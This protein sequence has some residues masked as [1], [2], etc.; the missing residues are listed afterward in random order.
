MAKTFPNKKS[1]AKDT[2]SQ[3][4][5]YCIHFIFPGSGK[6]QVNPEYLNEFKNKVK[7]ENTS[8]IS[9]G[10]LFKD[11]DHSIP[12]EILQKGGYAV[13]LA[14]GAL[15]KVFNPNEFLRLPLP[16][17][18]QDKKYFELSFK[19]KNRIDQAGLI[20]PVEVLKYLAHILNYKSLESR[21]LKPIL[22]KLGFTRQ[23][24]IIHQE[25]PVIPD[26][27]K[28]SL[29]WERVKIDLAWNTSIPF[30]ETR[31]ASFRK[32][33]QFS[34]NP[35][36][37][38]AF[39]A[40]ALAIFI[41][42]PILSLDAGLSGDDTKHYN[43]AVKVFRYF[44]EDDPSALNDPKYKLN[45]YG[46]SF[47]FFTYLIIRLFNLEENPYEARHVMVALTGAATI[48]CT[49]LLV[50][51][52]AGYS[53]GWIALILMF[54][55]PR[56]LGHAF[57]NPM[58]VPFALGNIFT[59][60]HIILFLKKLP[61][62]STRSALWIALGIGWSNGIRI[63]GLLLVPYLFLFAGLYLLIH[64]W[65]W[66]FFSSGWWRFALRGLL[67]LVLISVA[68]YLLS[69]LTWPY[70]LQDIINH[71]IQAFKVMTNIQV[72]IR[73]LYD[74][75]IHWSD[76][77]PWHYIPQN[78]WISVPVII[79]VGWMVSAL[80]WYM[81]R[82]LKQGYFYFM[83]WFTILFPV[84]FIIYRES[85]VYGGWRHMMFIYPSMLA[86]AAMSLSRFL[87]PGH[88]KWITY[89]A[90]AVLAVG[91]FHP[92]RHLIRNHPNTY[93]YFNE[94]SGGIKNT[95]GSFETDYYANSLKPA[96]DIFIEEILPEIDASEEHRVRVVSNSAIG[97]YF[98]NHRD[99]VETLYSR[100]YDRGKYDW[101]YAILYCNYLHP[102]QLNNGLWP[103]K[104]TIKEIRVDDVVV[105]AIIERKNKD[106][107][108]GSTL[109]QKG[110]K[111]Q[112][113]NK[114][115]DA[116]ELLE[117]AI[118]YD[119]H[120][121]IAFL[122][123][124]NGYSA[125]LRF[126]ESRAAM[127]RLLEYYPDYDKALNTKGYSYLI[128]ANVKE[129]PALIDEAIRNINM[130]VKSNYKFYS[131]Y[132]NLGLCYGMKNDVD[133]AIYNF[134][135]AIRYNGKFKAAYQKLAEVYDYSGNTEQ[136]NLVR[137]QLNRIQ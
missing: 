41:L 91:L 128:E 88:P 63:G 16:E 72:S 9:A 100:Y 57:N 48:L 42:L 125:F 94:W 20:I 80:T 29:L 121:E 60:Y 110:L 55:S 137:A 127:N 70:A 86:L 12:D 50:R 89:L 131:G 95:Y 93:I 32:L 26:P 36:F 71:P 58:D 123:L 46:Q 103:P 24:I 73:V 102:H 122:E 23:E 8:R 52:F 33:F 79:L 90:I 129:D 101:D 114:I 81:D 66:K 106:D 117:N 4:T 28:I 126:E 67:T 35:L 25:A 6:N 97:Y 82:K 10:F 51:L 83:L 18:L 68:G 53:G 61:R 115:S 85:N 7:P 54:L 30:K 14:T 3:K 62:I 21:L 69:I 104:N 84:L 38:V 17:A 76:N 130:A 112:N 5:R 111:E 116:I 119:E 135:Q 78:I 40:T 133:N 13:I 118:S 108:F 31:E 124:A 27:F 34:E 99:Q 98:R 47:D 15:N 64:K 39:F 96:A 22:Q 56:F 107:Y 59:L 65:P 1:K 134:K 113:S 2:A 43:H 109:L 136:A 105:A 37:R 75:L 132:Y 92:L 45:F 19:G 49:A 87:R 44:T 120:N 74:G 77:L 11:N